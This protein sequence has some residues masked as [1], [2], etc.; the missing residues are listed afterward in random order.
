MDETMVSVIGNES[1][2]VSKPTLKRLPAYL[3]YLR[4]YQQNGNENISAPIIAKALCLNEVQVRKD[5]AAI[6]RCSGRPKTGYTVTSVIDD[7][8]EFLGYKN[9]KDAL[10]V[11][12]GHLGRALLSY[13]GFEQYGMNIVVAFDKDEA[14]AGKE[15]SGKPVFSVNRLIDL[16]ARLQ[17]KIG[18]ITVPATD[19]QQVCNQL[20]QA[21]I[22][23]IWNFAPVHLIVPPHTMVQN[24]NMAASLA[25]LSQNLAVEI[26]N[27]AQFS[28]QQL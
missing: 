9:V 8:E 7:I 14:L 1:I 17:L 15:I 13:K 19:A 20:V 21:G 11:G 18:I 6:S 16:P 23:A 5:L 28:K 22:R 24:E 2:A 10:L 3:N 4:F 12:V 26:K 25:M 27:D